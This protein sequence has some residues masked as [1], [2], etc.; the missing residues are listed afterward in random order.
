[1]LVT[2]LLQAG[3]RY[4]AGSADVYYIEPEDAVLYLPPPPAVPLAPVK[5]WKVVTP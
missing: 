2:T 3:G 4:L 5:S 1:V